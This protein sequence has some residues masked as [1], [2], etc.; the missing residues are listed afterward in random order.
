[1]KLELHTCLYFSNYLRRL[2]NVNISN[3]NKSKHTTLLY[4]FLESFQAEV[5]DCRGWITNIPV[6]IGKFTL[7]V[8]KNILTWLNIV[9]EI[10]IQQVNRI[11]RKPFQ[12]K[13]TTENLS[14]FVCN[15]EQTNT[16]KC[17]KQKYCTFSFNHTLF[18]S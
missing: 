8:G 17:Q 7:P 4:F 2:L 13:R 9:Q 1:M 10:C 6:T 12:T 18:S 15:T 16:N 14:C 11:L 3:S 5:S